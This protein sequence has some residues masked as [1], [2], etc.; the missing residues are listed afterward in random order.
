M[1]PSPTLNTKRE[2]KIKGFEKYCKQFFVSIVSYFLHLAWLHGPLGNNYLGLRT[3]EARWFLP[4]GFGLCLL[5]GQLRRRAPSQSCWR[6]VVHTGSLVALAN[7]G[8]YSSGPLTRSVPRVHSPD[9]FLGPM[10]TDPGTCAPGLFLRRIHQ[11][12]SPG[13]FTRPIRQ[14]YSPGSF[15]ETKGTP[16]GLRGALSS[17]VQGRWRRCEKEKTSPGAGLLVC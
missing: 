17:R 14:V 1:G 13:P 7:L 16:S 9:L 2:N 6:Y 10:Q 5:P 12:H 11:A 15:A 3:H 4:V 8:V